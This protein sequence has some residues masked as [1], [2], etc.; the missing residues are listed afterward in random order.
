MTQK[1]IIAELCVAVGYTLDA[2]DQRKSPDHQDDCHQKA[3]R[4]LQR[5]VSDPNMKKKKTLMDS[6]NRLK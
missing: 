1:E 4:I 3:I 2:C 6:I 5:V